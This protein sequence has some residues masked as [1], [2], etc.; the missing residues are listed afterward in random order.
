MMVGQ[1]Y[2]LHAETPKLYHNN[3]DGTFT[4]VSS[5]MHLD[6]AILTMGANFGDMDNDGWLDVYL[7][8][9]DSTY[10]ALLPNRMFRNAEGRVYQDVTTAVDMGHLQKG[11]GVAFADLRRNGTEDLFEEM[12]GA[13]PGDVYQS[14]LYRNPG[15]GNHS[16]TI[17]LEGVKSNSAAFGARIDVVV[18]EPGDVERHIFRT[19]GYGSSFGGNPLRQH[20]G[21]G[22]AKR[23]ESMTVTWPTTGVMDRMRDVPVDTSY[24]LREGSGK[25]QALEGR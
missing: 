22:R 24:S 3:H 23:V 20:I 4:D 7:G 9:G 1:I 16:I 6:R 8:T 11:H 13:Q 10:Q 2:L 25:L 14:A 18:K 15:N 21:V 12:G 5:A 17:S 19:V